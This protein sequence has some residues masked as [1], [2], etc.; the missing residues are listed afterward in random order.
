HGRGIPGDLRQGGGPAA[1]SGTERGAPVWVVKLGGSLASNPGL[2]DWLAVLARRGGGR[3]V[4]VPGGG[5][6]A[7]AVRVA[8][9][10]WNFP[11]P[12]EH[13]MALPAMEQYGLLLAGMQPRLRTARTAAEIA[14]ILARGAAAVWLPFAMTAGP[15]ARDIE[16]SWNMTSDSLA[17]W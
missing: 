9:R 17:A 2:K 14:E 8:Q 11:D 7:D 1:A 16:E 12:V 10:R 5:P 15:E 4:I 6:F 13:R 3:V